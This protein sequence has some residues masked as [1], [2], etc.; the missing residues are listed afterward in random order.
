MKEYLKILIRTKLFSGVDEPEAEAMVKCLSP[1]KKDYIKGAYIYRSGEQISS[2]GLVLCGSVHILKEDYWGNRTILAEIHEGQ[3]FGEAYAC[4]GAIELS[5]SAVAAQDTAVLFLD[6]KRILT[7]CPTGC[8]FHTRLIQNLIA[9]LADKNIRLTG[10]IEH[11][12][13]RRLRDKILSYLSD[14][15]KIQGSP[16]FTIPFSRQELADYLSVDRSA[17]SNE[18]CKLRDEGVLQFERK[19]FRLL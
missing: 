6:V 16:D 12:S 13:Q 2:M 8:A 7:L 5:V 15:S 1:T 18:L 17:L 19:K 14:V 9:E 4:S 3:L 11:M 10:K